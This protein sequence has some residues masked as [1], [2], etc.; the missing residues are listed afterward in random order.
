MMNKTK[1]EGTKL[2][3]KGA[4]SGF[5]NRLELKGT[6]YGFGQTSVAPDTVDQSYAR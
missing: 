5:I 6:N 2:F 1:K 3:K 4:Q